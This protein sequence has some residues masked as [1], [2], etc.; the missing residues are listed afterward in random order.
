MRA[1]DKNRYLSALAH[2]ETE[3]VCFQED[4]FEPTFCEQLIGR[5]LPPVRSYELPPADVVELNLKA[6]NDVIFAAN[7]WEL[8]RNNVIDEHGR[9]HYVDGTIKSRRDLKK[10]TCPNLD[11]VRQRIEQLIAAAQGTGLGLKYRPNNS[12]FLAEVGIGYQDYYVNLK[13]DPDFI[14]EFQKRVQDYCRAELETALTYPIDVVQLSILFGSTM[15]PLV[16]PEITEEFEYPQLRHAVRLIKDHA[17]PVSLHVDGVIEPY[18]EEF[19]ALGF[20][21]I[22]PIEPCGG[23]QDIYQVKQRHGHRIALHGNIDVGAVLVFGTL[24]QVV[25]DTTEHLDRL[26]P[27]GGYVCAS[28]HNITEAVPLEN[29][30]AMR[31]TVHRYRC[32]APMQRC[33]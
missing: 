5:S 21:I 9:K 33:S 16:S 24:E 18:I 3:Q 13:I 28:S 1:P 17:K 12:L 7:L 4:E 11:T 19:I 25:R 23:L 20:D 6:G 8:G 22:H 32:A 26:T 30:R 15:G 2:R 29:F 27:G 14:H 10:V 31:D